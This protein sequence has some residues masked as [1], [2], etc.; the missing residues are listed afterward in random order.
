M[1]PEDVEKWA[2]ER[3]TSFDINDLTR[4]FDAGKETLW[5]AL[6]ELKITSYRDIASPRSPGAIEEGVIRDYGVRYKI[7]D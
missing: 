6:E 1:D 4:E 5:D 7:N 2:V 3:E